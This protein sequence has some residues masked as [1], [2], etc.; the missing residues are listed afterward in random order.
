MN[1]VTKKAILTIFIIFFFAP[2]S[3]SFLNTSENENTN[4]SETKIIKLPA[5]NRLLSSNKGST[6]LTTTKKALK[7][8][9]HKKFMLGKKF[10][11]I[12]FVE[13]PNTRTTID[14]LGPLYN[15]FSC[16]DCH[17]KNGRGILQES[18]NLSSSS[19]V[20]KLSISPN[21]S[22]EHQEFVKSQGFVPEPTYGKELSKNGTTEVDFEGE[23]KIDFE[24]KEVVFPD[25]EIVLLQKP[26]YALENLNYGELHKDTNISYQMAPSL[27]GIGFI[28]QLSNEDILANEDMDDRDKDGIS[29]HANLVYSK[30]T[31]NFELG[32]YGS[33]ASVFSLKEKVANEA[34]D[35][36]G[37]TTSVNKDENCTK[38]QET[39]NEASKSKDIDLDDEKLDA[40]IYY[41]QN[42]KTYA[43]KNT[44]EYEEGV[45]IF[46]E[47]LCTKCHIRT[48][49]TKEGIKISPFSDFLLHD[50][51]EDLADGR[52]EFLANENEWRTAPLWGLALH[53]SINKEEPRLLHDG[54][55][56]SYEEAILWHGGEAQNTK[57]RYMNL[58]KE[59]REKLIK[60]LQ[61]L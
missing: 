30:I 8:K 20:A 56:R 6:L 53:K 13:T 19:L 44:K 4:K 27:N 16:N 42:T 31:Q 23:I 41:L 48:F 12:S 39:C 25:G 35:N 51:G 9:D 43:P 5:P 46:E 33:K 1:N 49:T 24:V 38:S 29:G 47:I 54:R 15:A 14:G 57:E 52:P 40:I 61:E 36:M 26:K 22:L 32:K 2:F 45:T 55:A 34:L 18:E 60:F 10:F 50:M 21:E 7:S 3:Y 58:S 59:K 37:L 28:E 17:I 11:S